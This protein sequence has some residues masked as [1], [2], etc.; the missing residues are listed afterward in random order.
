MTRFLLA[1]FFT[2][3]CFVANA[4]QACYSYDYIQQLTST[5]PQL[6]KRIRDF[7]TRQPNL[8]NK[9]IVNNITT[10]TGSGSPIIR[11]PVVVHVLYNNE[12]QNISDEQI[13]SQIDA[14]NR[15]F[16]RMNED[17]INAPEAYRA[18]GADCQIEFVLANVDPKGF[19][20][21]GILRRRT[22]IQFFNSDDR[23]KFTSR[24]GDD[25][26][27]TESYLNIWVGNL[28]GNMLGYAS[29][30]YGPRNTDGVVVSWSSFGTVNVASPSFN[31]GRVAV[32]E[33]GHW[34]GLRHIWGD[35]YCGDDYIDDTPSQERASF[36]CPTGNPVSCGNGP[37]GNMYMN[38][39]DAT[40]DACTNM[41]T[42][43]QVSR[44]RSL[45]Q[46]GE[47]R[48]ALLNS[49]GA[50]G[51]GLP[52]PAEAPLEPTAEL[53]GLFPNP[54]QSVLTID[55]KGNTELV[56]Q[57][58]SIYNHLGQL[59]MQ[60]RISKPIL[61]MKVQSLN[62]GIYYVK[63]ANNNARKVVKAAGFVN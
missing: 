31:L 37:T 3:A 10:G 13:Q 8:L 63:I 38:Y 47:Y 15:D 39:M 35:R 16:R 19:A 23:I 61:T 55:L 52:A 18:V 41:F 4:Q 46:P 33:V 54:V 50:A 7:E 25:P 32:H 49:K 22:N 27:D 56:G 21:T 43:G 42:N 29:P 6:A 1:C 59:V 48:E 20:T 57:T 28:I 51:N 9:E 14:L 62:D 30:V 34:L 17:T 44:M 5:D 2:G 36:G 11:I 58:V 40:A 26:W 24:G 60:E 53:I 12:R 45:F